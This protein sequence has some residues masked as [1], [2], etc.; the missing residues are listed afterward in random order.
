[1]EPLDLPATLL[2]SGG[3][4]MFLLGTAGLRLSMPLPR[5]W[6]R[7]A[8][9]AVVLLVA[10]IGLVNTALQLGAIVIVLVAGLEVER[11]TAKSALKPAL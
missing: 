8:L 2:L 4:A 5:P 11:R 7:V 6:E 3:V 9:A 10:P 1:M